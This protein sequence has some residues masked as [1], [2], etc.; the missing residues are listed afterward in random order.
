M[1]LIPA[2]IYSNREDVGPY[3]GVRHITGLLKWDAYAKA[4]YIAQTVEEKVAKGLSIDDSIKQVQLQ[5]A[6]RSDVIKKQYLCFKIMKE[7]EDD[8][9]FETK[10]IKDKFSL[11]TVALNSP[12]IRL[13]VGSPTHKDAKFDSRIIPVDKIEQLRHLLTWIYGDGKREPILS[14][15]RRITKELAQYWQVKTQRNI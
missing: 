10:N 12:A 14:D 11:L 8:L 7:A 9:N 3:L 6:D 5:I 15:S 13:Y 1:S 4:A 2:I